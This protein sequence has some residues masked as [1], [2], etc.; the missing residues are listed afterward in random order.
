VP[1]QDGNQKTVN[2]VQVPNGEIQRKEDP[3]KNSKDIAQGKI[4]K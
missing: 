1:K 4:E 3:D 2:T